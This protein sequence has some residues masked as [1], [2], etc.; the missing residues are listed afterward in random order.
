MHLKKLIQRM[1]LVVGLFAVCAITV[2]YAGIRHA[3]QVSKESSSK[4]P[5]P[6][7]VPTK[8]PAKV[9]ITPTLVTPVVEEPPAVLTETGI[10]LYGTYD[11]NDLL[12]QTVLESRPDD[13]EIKIPQIDGLKDLEVQEKINQEIYGRVEELLK[14]YPKA[15]YGSFY[16]RGNFANVISISYHVGDGNRYEQLYL[17]YNLVTG[18]RL[19]LKDL[20]LTDAD[21]TQ[22]VRRAFYDML[23]QESIYDEDMDW[24]SNTAV[25]PDENQVYK[26]VKGYMESEDYQFMFTPS[27]ICFYFKNYVAT[28][29]MVD[30]ADQIAVYSR[31]LT[32][33]SI[34]VRD[35]IGFE[36]VFTCADTQNYNAFKRIE[37]GYLEPNFWYDITVWNTYIE[38]RLAQ[39]KLER[40]YAM[41]EEFLISVEEQVEEYRTIAKNNPDKFYI[42]FLKPDAQMYYN[43]DT[44]QY[45]NIV[46]FDGNGVV[47]EMPMEVY[48]ATYRDKLIEAYRYVYFAMAGGAYI[49]WTEG[50]GAIRQF[51]DNTR[52]YNYV[53]GEELTELEDI[54][55]K[56][57]GYKDVIRDRTWDVLAR[58]TEYSWAEISALV[59]TLECRLDGISVYVT[60]PSLEDFYFRMVLGEFEDNMLK[61]F[62]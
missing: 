24:E 35:D 31:F 1:I 22:C 11:E 20:F 32:E 40:Y 58:K 50:D 12:I 14:K 17:N 30:E 49:D 16:V 51:L 60:I 15:N 53:T 8:A 23:A 2:T 26:L 39:D 29:R 6:T 48:E 21:I 57:S 7:F 25:S 33:E 46:E 38:N 13:V 4:N 18:E 62:D 44:Q 10:D 28:L 42:L 27:E 41:E 37:Y 34:F 19:E 54:F 43:S 55:H 3:K 9:S 45:A 36:N 59:D 52:A 5:T 61:I 47:Y 56:Y